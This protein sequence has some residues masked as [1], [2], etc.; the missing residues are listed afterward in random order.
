MF[1]NRTAIL[2]SLILTFIHFNLKGQSF[3]LSRDTSSITIKGTSTL[4]NWSMDVKAFDCNADFLLSNN[5]VKG[6]N[7]VA[8]NCLTTNIKSENSLMDKK[9]YTALKS[10]A[11]P[12]IKFTIISSEISSDNRKFSGSIIGNLLIAG[13]SKNISIPVNGVISGNN[14]IN[15]IDVNGTVNLKM[16]DFDVAAPVLFMGTLKTGDNI[17]VSFALQFVQKSSQ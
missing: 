13:K 12:G 14:K 17:T 6:I 15:K 11:F 4:H 9:A 7:N 16:S 2:F 5:Q 1:K 8:F 10:N 3:E